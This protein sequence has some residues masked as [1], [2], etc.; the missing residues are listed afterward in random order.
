MILWEETHK[1]WNIEDDA[2]YED[3]YN[4]DLSTGHSDEMSHLERMYYG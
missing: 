2:A 4:W 3:R 1:P